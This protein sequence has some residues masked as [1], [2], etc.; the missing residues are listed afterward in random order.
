VTRLDQGSIPG[1]SGDLFIFATAVSRP[2][3]GS[4]QPHIHWV[5]GSLYPGI[6][7]TGMKLTTHLHLVS[8]MRMFGTM[9]PFPMRLYG[10]VLN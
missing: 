2:A 7:R 10:V 5:P 8:K 3:V 6:N 1:G 9:P 4:T